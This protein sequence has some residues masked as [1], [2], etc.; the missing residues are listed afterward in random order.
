MEDSRLLWIHW[1]MYDH[2]TVYKRYCTSSF[3]VLIIHDNAFFCIYYWLLCLLQL[4]YDPYLRSKVLLLL[5]PNLYDTFSF[6]V[7]PKRLMPFCIQ[8]QFNFKLFILLLMRCF[9][10]EQISMAYFGLQVLEVF[11]FILKIP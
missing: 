6:L 1:I 4:A 8:L 3:Y 7:S 11:F 2:W 5:C 9:L 10:A